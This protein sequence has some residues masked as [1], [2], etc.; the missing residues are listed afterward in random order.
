M[1]PWINYVPW[2]VAFKSGH[3]WRLIYM[4]GVNMTTCNIMLFQCVSMWVVY[5]GFQFKD[6]EDMFIL[7][8][9]IIATF[10]MYMNQITSNKSNEF[11]SLSMIYSWVHLLWLSSPFVLEYMHST[12]ASITTTMWVAYM[13]TL[14]K[15]MFKNYIRIETWPKSNLKEW[16]NCCICTL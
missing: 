8:H 4:H 7:P 9:I 1:S 13:C 2:M 5:D 11:Y 6:W 12:P 15:I 16:K 3:I 10:C 14:W